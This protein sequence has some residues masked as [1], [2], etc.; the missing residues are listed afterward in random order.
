MSAPSSPIRAA[1]HM[2]KY[3]AEV[4]AGLD[5][6]LYRSTPAISSASVGQHV[7]HILDHF[8]SLLG[9][10][11][12]KI[13]YDTRRRD[14]RLEESRA[15]ALEKIKTTLDALEKIS[16]R[17]DCLDRAVLVKSDSGGPAPSWTRSSFGR[18]CQYV[19]SHTIHHFALV[20]LLLRAQ[21]FEPP[22]NF[23]VAPA[24]MRHWAQAGSYN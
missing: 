14:P 9:V 7:R 1:I 16:A 23:G 24:T 12:D 13:D 18:E 22:S 20:A 3:G 15:L 4:L 11:G 2:L 10:A 6:G 21:G 17:P 19:F 5:D 8:D